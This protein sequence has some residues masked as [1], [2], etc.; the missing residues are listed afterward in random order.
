MEEHRSISL[1]DQVF[2]RLEN[3]ILSGKYPIG[4]VLTEMRLVSDLGVSRTPIRE[5]LHRLGLEHLVETGAK[6]ILIIGVS[7]KDLED[8]F[9]VRERV[10]GLASRAAAERV[11]GE[12]LEQL[13]EA[14]EL[15]EFYVPRNDPEHVRGMDSRFHQLST[16]SAGAWCWRM[17]FC[18]F[19]GRCRNTAV[20]RWRITAGLRS[21]PPSTGAFSKPLPRMIRTLPNAQCIHIS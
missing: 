16:G 19:T 11:T 15:Q 6:G 7:R 13:R 3:D 2:E 20:F 5:A 21:P 1:A 4:T 12:D 10:E 17:S 8:I 14:V 9:A 18:R